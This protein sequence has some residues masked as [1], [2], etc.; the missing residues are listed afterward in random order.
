MRRAFR[1]LFIVL[2][3][4][5]VIALLFA[6]EKQAYAYADPGSGLLL[7]QIVG[8]TVASALF[9]VRARLRKLFRMDKNKAT[10]TPDIQP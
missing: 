4:F 3:V 9:I 5:Q 8:T 1:L 6:S 2:G 7:I 10:D